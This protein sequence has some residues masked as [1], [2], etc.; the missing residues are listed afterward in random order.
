MEVF[1]N[2]KDKKEARDKYQMNTE[3]FR[4]KVKVKILWVSEIYLSSIKWK[5]IS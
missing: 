1:L 3:Q 5:K 2:Y 4:S